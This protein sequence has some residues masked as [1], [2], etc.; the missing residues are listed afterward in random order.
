MFKKKTYTRS[1]KVSLKFTNTG[2]LDKLF[3]FISDY[4]KVVKFFIEIF[5]NLEKPPRWLN[6]EYVHQSDSKLS[7]RAIQAAGQQA[8]AVVRGTK[9]KQQ[10]RIFIYNKLLKEGKLEEAEKL[11]KIIESNLLTK[12]NI[13]HINPLLSSNFVKFDF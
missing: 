6:K 11:K 5:W 8:S 2:K 9:A 1:S 4:E 7:Y 10:R 13:E 3:S 12:P